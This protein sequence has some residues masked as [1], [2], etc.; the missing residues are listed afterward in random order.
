[1]DFL[2]ACRQLISFDSGPN[3]STLEMIHWLKEYCEH[4]G[5]QVEL[6]EEDSLEQKQ[7][8]ILV[9]PKTSSENRPPVEFLFQTHLD[10]RD[11]GSFNLWEK[12]SYNPFEAHIISE[13]I[14]G[15]GSADTKLDFLCKIAALEKLGVQKK[16]ILPPV[17]VGTY[18]E[19]TGMAGALKL[20]RKNKVNAK[21]ALIG[22]PTD[23]KISYASKGFAALEIQI[24]F[25]EEEISYRNEHDLK[26]STSTQSRV[27]HGIEA[28]GAT[29]EL[30]DNAIT[31]LFEYL[32]NLPQ[33][34]VIMNMEGGVNYNTVPSNAFLEVDI[35]TL[36][37]PQTLTRLTTIYKTITQ[38]QSDFKKYVDNEFSPNQP[39]LN[40][41]LVKTFKNYIQILA[42]CRI[43][44]S[45]QSETLENWLDTIKSSCHAVQ[46]QFQINDY[47][48]PFRVPDNS[49]LLKSCIDEAR[50]IGLESE[51]ITLS[52]TNEA[53]LFSRLGVECVCFGPGERGD[54]LHT[55]KE[56][57]KI[58]QLNQ[59]IEFYAR[60]MKRLCL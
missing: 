35:I 38:I 48:K 24:P 16:W 54:N 34:C 42:T 4:K 21:Y 28:H 12:T 52:S 9:R 30:G 22:E 17:L 32:L 20:I 49:I 60:L 50:S 53:S 47:K 44:P 29:P 6:Q 15:L 10:T 5:F 25:S 2:Q 31:K 45:I 23:L 39:T 37:K 27:F 3:Q 58:S 26:E 43:P 36:K 13:R 14:Y 59:A 40:I 41:G 1:L 55:A 56:S 57:V 19:E 46:C 7:A 8:N 11:P 51:I 18:G 33:N